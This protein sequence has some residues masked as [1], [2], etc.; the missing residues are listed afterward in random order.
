MPVAEAFKCASVAGFLFN[1]TFF[2]MKEKI[3]E[4]LKTTYA[5]LG[6]SDE[7]F[8]G[9]ASLLEK[10]VTEESQIATAIG[11]DEVQ[12]LLKTIQGN[13]DSW[14][15]KFYDTDRAL[16]DYKKAHPETSGKEGDKGGEGDGNEPEW[17][18]TLRQQNETLLSKMKERDDAERNTAAL[19][20]VR[21]SLKTKGCVN[22]G[23]LAL[24]L[25]KFAL[26]KD[27]T[28]DA[29]T[30]RLKARYDTSYTAIFGTAPVPP[31]GGGS[32]EPK[33]AYDAMRKSLAD[34]GYL[35][36]ENK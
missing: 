29:A 25:D 7:A 26:G 10:T 30:E 3:L 20:N 15:N 14:R 11:G 27:E 28:E 22:E 12:T 16:K 34:Q 6:L 13:I 18:K 5:K 32:G 2:E 9:V 1:Q 19:A 24:V 35:P 23:V 21:E 33:P 4:A 31:V 8:D 36:K 17:A